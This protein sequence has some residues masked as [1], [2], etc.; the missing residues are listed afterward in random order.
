MEFRLGEKVVYPNQGVGIIEQISTRNLSG[1]PETF[2]LLKL[3]GSGMRVMVPMTNVGSIG[4]RRVARSNEIGS[5]LGFLHTGSI[6]NLPDWK[7]RFKGNAE[8][9]RTGS[10]KDV[11]VVFKSLLTLSQDKPLSFREKRMLDRSW[12]ML[13]DEIA[14]VR[15]MQKDVVVSQLAKTLEKSHLKMPAVS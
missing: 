12:Q 11:A 9:M 3:N 15:G 2:Y 5:V 14:V 10:L 8:K 13:V 6:T 1:Q 4:L 7:S